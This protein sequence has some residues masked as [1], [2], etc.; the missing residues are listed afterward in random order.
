MDIDTL[1]DRKNEWVIVGPLKGLVHTSTNPNM[2]T[3]EERALQAEK[4]VRDA[5]FQFKLVVLDVPR[6][7]NLLGVIDAQLLAI[8]LHGPALRA[9]IAT[10][11]EEQTNCETNRAVA[12]VNAL[13]KRMRR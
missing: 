11:S 10:Q 2:P 1:Y 8:T 4:S 6:T 9:H 13:S 5:L 12:A 3:V 7:D